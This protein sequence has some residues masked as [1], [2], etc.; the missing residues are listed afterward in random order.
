MA[1]YDDCAAA[2]TDDLELTMKCVVHWVESETSRLQRWN[3]QMGTTGTGVGEEDF[4]TWMLILT[5]SLVF[6]M[7]AG[8]CALYCIAFVLAAAN[9]RARLSTSCVYCWFVRWFVV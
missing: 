2:H 7:Q 9:V 6:F 3:E 8:E 1:V 5:G 4:T